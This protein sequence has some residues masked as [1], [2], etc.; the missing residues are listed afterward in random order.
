MSRL[1]RLRP[2]YTYYPSVETPS[3]LLSASYPPSNGPYTCALVRLD[4][5]RLVCTIAIVSITRYKLLLRSRRLTTNS[6]SEL[7]LKLGREY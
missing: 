4:R 2:Y 6:T 3:S 5:L 7:L 1:L